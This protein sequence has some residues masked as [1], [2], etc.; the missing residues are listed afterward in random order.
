MILIGIAGKS[1]SGKTTLSKYLEQKYVNITRVGVDEIV[2]SNGFTS[3]RNE[4]I[5]GIANATMS[6]KELKSKRKD[7]ASRLDIYVNKKVDEVKKQKSQVIIVDYALLYEL[8]EI[9]NKLNYK[10]LV[11]RDKNIIKKGLIKRSGKEKAKYLEI[12]NEKICENEKEIKVDYRIYNEENLETFYGEIDN[13]INDIF[14]KEH[15]N[16]S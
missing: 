5:L 2:R 9:W 12:V 10:I 8:K 1:G 15:I 3:T 13:I 14:A 16:N 7:Y 6:E 11:T 4:I